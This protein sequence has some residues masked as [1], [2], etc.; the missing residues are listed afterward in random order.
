MCKETAKA[1]EVAHYALD[2]EMTLR[3]AALKLGYVTADEYDT[4]V[5]PLKMVHPYVA[6]K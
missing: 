1:S 3:D 5:D 4:V 6:K 2:R